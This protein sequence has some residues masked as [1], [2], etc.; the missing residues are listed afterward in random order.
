[1]ASQPE[2]TMGQIIYFAIEGIS[3]SRYKQR[4][5]H[6]AGALM[7]HLLVRILCEIIFT[8]FLREIVFTEKLQEICH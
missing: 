6:L 8:N 7:E 4:F 1:M 3:P 5:L 2:I